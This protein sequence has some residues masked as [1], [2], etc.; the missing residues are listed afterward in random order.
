MFGALASWGMFILI[1]YAVRRL[2]YDLTAPKYK[3]RSPCYTYN[4][5]TRWQL[6]TAGRLYRFRCHCD[7]SL[8]GK[9]TLLLALHWLAL[10]SSWVL[11]TVFNFLCPLGV[12]QKKQ[13][14]AW[15]ILRDLFHCRVYTEI[16]Y[17]DTNR[18]TSNGK[19]F[20]WN[21]KIAWQIFER[22]HSVCAR[23]VNKVKTKRMRNIFSAE[24]CS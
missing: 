10:G 6:R 2:T 21:V 11:I 5:H 9:G 20:A 16:S 13:K 8:P 22:A 14:W 15:L 17:S 1:I 7:V 12:K 19:R 3:H 24:I 23:Y 18:A 4:T